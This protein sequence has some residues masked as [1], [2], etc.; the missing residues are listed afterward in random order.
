MTKKVYDT[1][2]NPLINAKAIVVI[3]QLLHHHLV[4]AR[5]Y[6]NL[7]EELLAAEKKISAP[8]HRKSITRV[9]RLC[10]QALQAMPVTA[11]V[12]DHVSALA[13]PLSNLA[14]RTLAAIATAVRQADFSRGITF[15]QF[16][17]RYSEFF[18]SEN[19][20]PYQVRSF[21][22]YLSSN[23]AISLLKRRGIVLKDASLLK[24]LCDQVLHG[25]GIEKIPLN[26]EAGE[27]KSGRERPD[28]SRR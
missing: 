11:I 7:L 1:Q 10:D 17:E 5:D 14:P 26:S 21:L 28:G 16:W 22:K 18:K 20:R 2:I 9:R 24:S 3:M 23:N 15:R 8:V 4:R 13:T 19:V 6:A 25:T 12:D 27:P